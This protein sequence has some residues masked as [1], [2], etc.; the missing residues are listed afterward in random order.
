M[1][2]QLL[3]LPLVLLLGACAVNGGPRVDGSGPVIAQG[4]AASQVD[5]FTALDP[6]DKG[7]WTGKVQQIDGKTTPVSGNSTGS[8]WSAL[9]LSVLFGTEDGGSAQHSRAESDDVKK[10]RVRLERAFHGFYNTA[11]LEGA[12]ARR[13]RI[14]EQLVI[15]SNQ[16]CGDFL[17]TLHG[18][19]ATGNFLLG[20]LATATAGAGAIVTNGNSARLLSGLGSIFGGLRAEMNEDYYRNVFSDSLE[21]AIDSGRNDKLAA[22]RQR[23]TEAISSYPVEAA[24]ADAITYN[25]EC[26]LVSGLSRITTAVVMSDDPAGLRAFRDTFAKAGFDARIGIQGTLNTAGMPRVGGLPVGGL[27]APAEAA[28]ANAEIAASMA[29]LSAYGKAAF[30]AVGNLSTSSDAAKTKAKNDIIA[31]LGTMM[32]TNSSSGVGDPKSPSPKIKPIVDQISDLAD[33][34]MNAETSMVPAD[35]KPAPTADD[36]DRIDRLM[37]ANDYAAAQLLEIFREYADSAKAGIDTAV[38]TSQQTTDATAA[39]ATTTAH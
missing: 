25:D 2:T 16:N 15:A 6:D 18:T 5:L 31:A 27:P 37:H 28:A 21:K 39:A 26:S 35:S 36:R 17:Q 12:T 32:T 10:D 29:R 4:I 20:S 14:V 30:D 22:I 23:Y 13:N 3:P 9:G 19:Q 7:D 38:R 1:K 33:R 11:Y 24:V 8:L 34:Y